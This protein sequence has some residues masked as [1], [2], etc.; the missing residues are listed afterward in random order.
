MCS[1]LPWSQ[2]AESTVHHRPRSKTG[3]APLA[4]NRIS[5]S[6]LGDPSEKSPP[7]VCIPPTA[8]I[9]M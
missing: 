1:R 2:P 5:A 7:P 3:M 8:S 9:A 4:P 6:P